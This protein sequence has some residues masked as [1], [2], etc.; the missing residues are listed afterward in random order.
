MC[1]SGSLCVCE[2][3]LKHFIVFDGALGFCKANSLSG[4]FT[5]YGKSGS[6]HCKVEMC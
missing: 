4:T 6:V 1:G 2:I 5:K 3:I